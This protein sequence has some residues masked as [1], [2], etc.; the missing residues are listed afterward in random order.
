VLAKSAALT[1]DLGGKASTHDVGDAVAQE[2]SVVAK[3]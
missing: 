3:L 2:I 1:P